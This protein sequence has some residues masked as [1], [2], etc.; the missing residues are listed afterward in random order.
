MAPGGGPGAILDSMRAMGQ[1]AARNAGFANYRDFAHLDKNRFDYTPDDCLRFHDAVEA[2]V[3]PAVERLMRRRR[4]HMRLDS[5]RPWDITADPRGRPPLNPL[6]AI[7]TLIDRAGD[8]FAPV[9]PE[10]SSYYRPVAQA[11]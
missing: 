2:A 7:A 1:K 3:L 4:G 8:G 6:P 10:F 11:Q 5:L 9:E